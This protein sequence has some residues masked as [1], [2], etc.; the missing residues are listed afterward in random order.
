LSICGLADSPLGHFGR[1]LDG[2]H[3]R[4]RCQRGASGRYGRRRW[5]RLCLLAATLVVVFGDNHFVANFSRLFF[6]RLFSFARA[7]SSVELIIIIRIIYYRTYNS[8]P[9]TSLLCIDL[10]IYMCTYVRI[11]KYIYV[12]IY[13]QRIAF[14]L[15]P[16][17]QHAI[18]VF[19]LHLNGDSA[20]VLSLE[21][22]TK[23]LFI[24]L[25]LFSALCVHISHTTSA[26]NFIF[27]REICLHIFF[28]SS[29]S[30]Y[31]A[32]ALCH[33]GWSGCHTIFPGRH[34]Q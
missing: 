22:N 3:C 18:F 31:T 6:S 28:S 10:H 16:L 9:D 23:M 19:S 15:L 8:P 33:G 29:A 2:R 7:P 24:V 26:A 27:F 12:R 14:L 32:F 13:L 5:G 1:G 30:S 25:L 20:V 11:Y 21:I 34:K 17:L 4:R